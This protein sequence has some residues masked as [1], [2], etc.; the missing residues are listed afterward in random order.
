MST[1][2]NTVKPAV[3]GVPTSVKFSFIALEIAVLAISAFFVFVPTHFDPSLGLVQ[4][5]LLPILLI[6]SC[7]LLCREREIAISGLFVFVVSVF[8]ALSFPVF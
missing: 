8:I 2:E 3:R 5:V 7:L 4:L 1:P 6:S